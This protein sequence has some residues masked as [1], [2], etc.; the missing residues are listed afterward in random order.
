MDETVSQ[1]VKRT[2]IIKNKIKKKL[3]SRKEFPGHTLCI[4][5]QLPPHTRELK[6][7]VTFN[8]K[9]NYPAYYG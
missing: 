8:K 4:Y 9:C 7:T 6:P 3:E 1:S 2:F 5:S